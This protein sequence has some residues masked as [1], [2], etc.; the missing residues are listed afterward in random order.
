MLQLTNILDYIYWTENVWSGS[1]MTWNDVTILL[2][3]FVSTN[4]HVYVCVLFKEKG[5]FL[6]LPPFSLIYQSQLNSWAVSCVC[7]WVFDLEGGIANEHYDCYLV[8][9]VL[10]WCVVEDMVIE[11]DFFCCCLIHSLLDITLLP[12]PCAEGILL[13]IPVC[14]LYMC[15]VNQI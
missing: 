12:F 6:W 1:S 11:M 3:L 5:G 9:F 13:K 14:S 2:W 10:C 4:I 8:W 15:H 7:V